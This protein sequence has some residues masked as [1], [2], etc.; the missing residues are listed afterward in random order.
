MAFAGICTIKNNIFSFIEQTLIVS[1]CHAYLLCTDLSADLTVLL[2]TRVRPVSED[3]IVR[4]QTQ[5]GQLETQLLDTQR[6]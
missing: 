4:L 5:C 1:P 6:K 2:P 3:N